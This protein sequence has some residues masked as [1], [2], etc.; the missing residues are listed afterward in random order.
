MD[1]IF[2]GADRTITFNGALNGV[3][4][5][6][7]TVEVSV[8]NITTGKEDGPYEMSRTGSTYTHVY[9][10]LEDGTYKAIGEAAD[11]GH[12]GIGVDEWRAIDPRA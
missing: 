9:R 11:S 1:T 6:T 12:V 7:A 4:D 8:L 3:P 2:T 10:S 5:E